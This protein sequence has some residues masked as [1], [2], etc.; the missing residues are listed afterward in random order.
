MKASILP[1]Y[2]I[3]IKFLHDVVRL[4]CM[5]KLYSL[6]V[7]K[8]SDLLLT[9]RVTDERPT[10]DRQTTR[11]DVWHSWPTQRDDSAQTFCGHVG[12]SRRS[13]YW[14]VCVWRRRFTPKSL[15]TSKWLLFWYWHDALSNAMI[16]LDYSNNPMPMKEKSSKIAE[17]KKT[18]APNTFSFFPQKSRRVKL[19][20]YLALL[21]KNSM[22]S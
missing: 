8:H 16:I 18:N 10:A 19:S 15:H 17:R 22:R 12:Q 11:I 1:K 20:R 3:R 21:H 5:M 14:Y 7:N 9:I 2:I 6:Y 13:G 4:S